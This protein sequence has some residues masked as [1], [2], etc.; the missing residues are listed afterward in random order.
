MS[1]LC[2]K[3][4]DIFLLHPN[5]SSIYSFEE[6]Y[7]NLRLF[8]IDSIK[9]GET[10]I[11]PNY[12]SMKFAIDTKFSRELFLCLGDYSI[13]NKFYNITCDACFE[14]TITPELEN[15][16]QCVHCGEIPFDIETNTNPLNYVGYLFKINTEIRNELILDLK[17]R[18][19]S[20]INNTEEGTKIKKTVES[21]KLTYTEDET[22]RIK[23]ALKKAA[24]E[25][26]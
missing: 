5:Y 3:L 25:I 13:L 21:T 22:K 24:K 7:P 15:I 14:T 18:P 10:Y 12:F 20:F 26:A 1:I 6:I 9:N 19:S 11:D 23:D 4:K 2:T 16:I 17:D 8:F